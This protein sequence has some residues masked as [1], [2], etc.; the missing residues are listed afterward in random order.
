ML[1]SAPSV[2]IIRESDLKKTLYF[3]GTKRH[4]HINP[5]EKSNKQKSSNEVNSNDL[6]KS[7]TWILPKMLLK[8]SYQ[9][10]FKICNSSFVGQFYIQDD[11]TTYIYISL[12]EDLMSPRAFYFLRFKFTTK[13]KVTSTSITSNKVGHA[14]H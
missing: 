13:K 1:R 6:Q 11:A 8:I 2:D 3:F 12:C 7:T 4:W 10:I 5:N 14:S 9:N